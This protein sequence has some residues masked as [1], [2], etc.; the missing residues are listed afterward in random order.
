MDTKFMKL[1]LEYHSSHCLPFLLVEIHHR[2]HG[3]RVLVS[4]VVLQSLD[5]PI[6]LLFLAAFGQAP[7]SRVGEGSN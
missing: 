4:L 6:K 3:N 2:E 7:L 5:E 1:R